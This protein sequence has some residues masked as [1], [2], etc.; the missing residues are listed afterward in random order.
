MRLLWLSWYC[1]FCEEDNNK[2]VTA[3]FAWC[4]ASPK[5]LTKYNKDQ[6]NIIPANAQVYFYRDE[7]TAIW[8]VSRL[9][10]HR[11]LFVNVTFEKGITWSNPTAHVPYT[12]RRDLPFE[13]WD[14]VD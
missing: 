11:L 9:P 10:E 3:S 12:I 6:L 5:W 8:A 14:D 4:A 1:T 2:D 13:F 7:K